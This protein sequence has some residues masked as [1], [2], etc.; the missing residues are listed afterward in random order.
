M[1]RLWLVALVVVTSCT[2]PVRVLPPKRVYRAPETNI[3]WIRNS[4]APETWLCVEL[5]NESAA[6][7]ERCV[8]IG[9]VRNWIA[10]AVEAN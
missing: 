9:V 7:T 5:F 4:D 3:I 10:T 6:Y 1:S 2:V 8:P